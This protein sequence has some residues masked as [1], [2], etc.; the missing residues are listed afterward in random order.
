MVLWGLLS[1]FFQPHRTL[2]PCDNRFISPL[3]FHVPYGLQ[4]PLSAC[5]TF[6]AFP[7]NKLSSSL[8]CALCFTK[9]QNCRDWKEFWMSPVWPTLPKQVEEVAQGH[10]QL[11]FEYFQG[12][13][14]H[15]LSGQPVATLTVKQLTLFLR[16]INHAITFLTDLDIFPSMTSSEPCHIPLL[17]V[18]S[19]L[20]LHI[21]HLHTGVVFYQM[22]FACWS[23]RGC[24]PGQDGIGHMHEQLAAFWL[25]DKPNITIRAELYLF[26]LGNCLNK[27]LSSTQSLEI[28]LK[29]QLSLYLSQNRQ[30][31]KKLLTGANKES[32]NLN[33]GAYSFQLP[34]L[35]S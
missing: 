28:S 24:A 1:S 11:G 6:L 5:S 32:P 19:T 3:T 4:Q 26:M 7:L 22:C 12:Q 16:G 15:S 9:S 2:K 10:G 13:R 14:I 33:E 27:L 17:K 23:G 25:L 34:M 18:P 29:M 21:L 35:L 8:P 31:L 30:W 20:N